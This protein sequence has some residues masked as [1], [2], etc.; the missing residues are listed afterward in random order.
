MKPRLLSAWLRAL[1]GI[2]VR[3]RDRSN[4]YANGITDGAPTA[5]Q[6]ADRWQLVESLRV[7]LVKLP[8]RQLQQKGRCAVQCFSSS[9][10]E[11]VL[12]WMNILRADACACCH[13]C[14]TVRAPGERRAF[15]HRQTIAPSPN[16]AVW[17]LQQTEKLNEEVQST[18]EELS[19]LFPQLERA[20]V[21]AREFTQI[22]RERSSDR[23][24]AWLRSATRSK[25]KE[26]V[27]FARGLGEDYEAVKN[28][29]C[30]EWSNGQLEGQVNR[31]ELIKR[32][33]YG[34]ARFDLLRARVL[35]SM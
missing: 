11:R 3:T 26:F 8:K 13:T 21:L 24:S 12:K 25:L 34:R 9:I 6:V 7:A 29:L 15:D 35:H 20:K 16:Q 10:T 27:S 23:F 1:H 22:V 18:K 14:C 19:Q 17:M 2:E 4:T 30:Y 31:L 32:Q 28:A 33:L 5:V